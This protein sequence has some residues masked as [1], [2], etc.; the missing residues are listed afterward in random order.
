MSKSTIFA[1]FAALCLGGTLL[2][3]GSGSSAPRPDSNR[4][5]PFTVT[6]VSKGTI[7]KAAKNEIVVE[8]DGDEAAFRV[9]AATKVTAE[10]GADVPDTKK[11]ALADLKKGHR[12]HVKYRASDDMALEVKVLKNKKS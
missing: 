4:E 3:Q 5:S 7:L 8:T 6:K 12:V 9:S 10:K 1:F 2:A 11:V